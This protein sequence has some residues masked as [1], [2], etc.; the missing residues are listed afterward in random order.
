MNTARHVIMHG[1]P[2]Y[3]MSY[4][5]WRTLVHCAV[6]VVASTGTLRVD[7]VASTV[8]SVVVDAVASTGTPCVGRRG[9]HRYTMW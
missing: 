9:G 4:I 7:V 3:T 5:T 2:R 1:E 6:D 8:P